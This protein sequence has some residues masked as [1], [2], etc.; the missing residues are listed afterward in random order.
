[1]SRHGE[2]QKTGY[3]Q[4]GVNIDEGNRF[5]S[6]IKS[7][8]ES[9]KINGV[10]GGIGGFAGLFSLAEFKD[11]EEPVLVSGADGVGTKLKVALMSEKYDTVGIDLVAMSVNDLLVTGA[12]PLFFL[13]YVAVG[14]L[15]P[16]TMKDVVL[17]VSEGCRQ[18]GCALLGGETAEMPGLYANKD[19]DLAGFAVGIIDKKKIIDGSN[20]KEGDVIIGLSSSGFHSNGY[21]LLRNILFNDLN[22][23][24]SDIFYDDVTVA[25]ALLTPTKIYSSVVQHVTSKVDVKGM[26]HITGG[27]FYDNIPRV[28]PKDI[29]CEIDISKVEMPKVI[30]RFTEVSDIDKHE[31]Y[32]VFNMGVGYIFVVDEKDKENVIKA[33]AE[34]GEKAFVIG[35]TC[36]G[37]N[38]VKIK[39]I[40]FD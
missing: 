29:A 16:E 38:D 37:N 22:Y 3:R 26:V 17:G 34:K 35:K 6:L 39:G 27:G 10:I 28:L 15:V 1:M 25:E 21:S 30:K 20:I 18:A 8:V 24:A 7:S 19:F 36:K 5:V 33:A 13:D 40:D 32:R 14:T 4:S 9:T 31:L 11:M 12:K 2:T 23:K